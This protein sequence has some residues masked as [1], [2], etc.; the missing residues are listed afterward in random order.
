MHLN[1]YL[2]TP[3][4]ENLY[5]NTRARKSAGDEFTVI[6]KVCVVCVGGGLGTVPKITIKEVD[7]LKISF[8][9]PHNQINRLVLI[10]CV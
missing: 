6:L 2:F 9:V 7:M 8:C 5:A 3:A 10:K 4:L 1:L